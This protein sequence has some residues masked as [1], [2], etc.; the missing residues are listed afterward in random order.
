M[1]KALLLSALGIAAA[2]SLNLDAKVA[3]QP[4]ELKPGMWQQQSKAIKPDWHMTKPG[5]AKKV[6]KIV[7]EGDVKITSQNGFS[8]LDMPDGSNWFVEL[9]YERELHREFEGGYKEYAYTRLKGTVYNDQLKKVGVIDTP[10]E[11]PEGMGICSSIDLGSLVTQKFFNSDANYEIMFTAYFRPKDGYGALPYTYVVSLRDNAP[12]EHITT[13]PG[14][15]ISAINTATDKWSEDY[16]LEFF[17]SQ[18]KSSDDNMSVTFDIYSKTTYNS[19]G[20]VK[21]AS[22]DV[23][24]R[25]SPEVTGY[26]PMPVMMTSR[27]KDVY[28]TVARYEKPYF[29]DQGGEIDPSKFLLTPDNNYIID[30]YKKGS[31]DKEFTLQS[32]TA[33]PCEDAPEGYIGRAYGLG[34]FGLTRD[35]TFDFTDDNSVA[36]IIGVSDIDMMFET[37]TSYVIVDKDGK[38]IK[39]FGENNMGYLRLSGVEGFPDQYVFVEEDLDVVGGLVY[40]FVDFP[41][42]ETKAV[43]P[44]TIIDSSINQGSA[45]LSMSMDR[46]P[47]G[48][49]Y[50]YVF[51][52][53][54]GFVD[55]DDNTCHEIIYL[56]TE[57]QLKR[58]DVVNAGKMIKL[59][60]PYIAG[61]AMNPYIFNTDNKREYMVLVQRQESTGSPK[62][63]TELLVVNHEGETLLNYPFDSQSSNILISLLQGSNPSIWIQY[64]DYVSG[65]QQTEFI[66][67]PLNKFKGEG[68]QASPY[69]IETAGDFAQI[70]K[71]LTSH[72]RVANDIDFGGERITSITGLFSGSLDGDGH[73]FRN[74]IVKD[75]PIFGNLYSAN[76]VQPCEV[77][78]LTLSNV[79][80]DGAASILSEGN[81]SSNIKVS[82]VH[83]HKATVND[84][85]SNGFAAFATQTGVNS[86]FIGCSVNID[87]NRPEA[88][89]FGGIVAELNRGGKITACN[90]TGTVKAGAYVGG[91]AKATNTTEN[92]ISDCHVNLEIEG[93]NTIGGIVADA[94]RG[95]VVRNIVEGSIAAHTP[96]T[97]YSMK[98]GRIET[99]NVG[100]VI[101]RLKTQP[102]N[103]GSASVSK[104]PIVSEN[105]VALT[106]ISIPADNARLIETTHRVVGRSSVN[107]D[108]EYIDEYENPDYDPNDP[109]SQEWII[110]WGDPAA[111]DPCLVNNYVAGDLAAV[112][113]SVTADNKST[114]GEK[115][116]S[117]NREFF[118]G[119]NYKFDGNEA[120]APWIFT[121][122]LPA[123]YFEQT[124]G[125]SMAFNPASVLIKTGEKAT[126]VLS[127]EKVEASAITYKASSE[128]GFAFNP[129][130]TDENGN[131]TIEIEML[132]EGAYTLTATFGSIEATLSI[133]GLSGIADITG[134]ETSLISFD[135]YSVNAED[136]AIAIYNVAGVKV[137]AGNDTVDASA[138]AKGIYIATA[139]TAQGRT[140]SIKIAVK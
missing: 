33:I 77:K 131:V 84:G 128:T 46:T 2:C 65:M 53:A 83:I 109:N 76:Q 94:D 30:L 61:N 92:T 31:W 80:V 74:F 132:E 14:Y 49:S 137:A 66:S 19:N 52:A 79:T 120:N 3:R 62:S 20:P 68:T 113:S 29:A 57:G 45:L 75:K 136:C 87:F 82:N 81:V 37:A 95:I 15:Y 110:V 5:S 111:A 126:V 44:C 118:E 114:E 100:G 64:A 55:N 26:E 138:L 91:I 17:G 85:S 90:V 12:A 88:E 24:M 42:F 28:I 122:T 117:L 112:D 123:L 86:E 98:D 47:A 51:S 50:E 115:A 129:V 34:L 121:E 6:N 72:Y 36:Y 21:I 89:H 106:S 11:L 27:G 134:D 35:I 23:D 70:A 39:T 73:T 107:E 13:M 67:L 125:A 96:G 32:T 58:V 133:T 22:Y 8:Y 97:H 56:D 4:F 93:A 18:H 127:L 40:H 101:G 54:A 63:H 140:S 59:I 9:N 105:V 41:S 7:T 103:M 135:G 38:T 102:N 99:M 116:S 78:N 48:S 108:P 119:L 16:Y 25:H 124:A 139:T 104:D 130:S 69:L 10:I 43:I 1:K 71:N 60:K